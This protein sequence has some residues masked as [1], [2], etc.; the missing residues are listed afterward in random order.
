MAPSTSRLRNARVILTHYTHQKEGEIGERDETCY[1]IYSLCG[2]L[3]FPDFDDRRLRLRL[4]FLQAA[5]Y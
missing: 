2:H 3:V 5:L 4:R 1:E